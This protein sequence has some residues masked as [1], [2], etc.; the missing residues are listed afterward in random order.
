[1]RT[2]EGLTILVPV[3]WTDR[4]LAPDEFGNRAVSRFDVISLLKVVEIARRILG[5]TR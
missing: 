2:P 5:P 4:S 3:E 1:M